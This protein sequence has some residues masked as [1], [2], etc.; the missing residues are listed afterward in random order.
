MIGKVVKVISNN[1]SVLVDGKFYNCKPRGK[2]RNL[3]IRPIVGDI[4]EINIEKKVITDVYPRKN[5]LIRPPISNVDQAIIVTSV[6]EPEFSSVLLDKLLVIIEYNNILPIICFTKLDLA[7]KKKLKEIKEYIDY[8]KS[9]GYQVYLNTELDKMKGIFKNKITVL[10]GQS[11]AGKSTLLN[12]LDSSLNLKTAP[13][14]KA[15]G[16]GKHTTRH[17]ELIELLGGLIADTPGFSA[18]TFKGMNKSD[19]RDNF[20]EFNLYRSN[21]KYKDCM[22]YNEQDCAVKMKVKEK[23]ILKSR[24]DN[25]IN[26]ISEE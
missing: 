1:Y 12:K 17:V 25:Y 2:F 26:F 19:I 22:H 24:Y 5:E 23:K 14:S 10:A 15:L 8:Y 13:I 11:G 16:R 18:I 4:V 6:K 21:C 3:N 20:I 7:D 9:I